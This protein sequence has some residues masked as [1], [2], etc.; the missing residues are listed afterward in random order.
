MESLSYLGIL[1]TGLLAGSFL[2]LVSDRL[3]KT[4]TFV[5]GR[6]K[7][8]FCKH[9]LNTLDLI[10]V[11]SF[12]LSLGKCRYCH[13]KISILHP[14]SELVTGIFFVIIFYYLKLNNLTWEFYIYYFFNFSLLLIIFWY[15]YKYYEI[16]FKIV[17]LGSIFS[18]IF[19]IIYLKNLTYENYLIELASWL[20]IF[21]F[22]FLVIWISKGGMGGGDLKLSIYLGI[23]L[24][25]PSSIYG[26]YYG[27][28]LGGMFGLLLLALGKK[29]LKSQIP[30]GPFLIIGSLL[31]LLI[32]NR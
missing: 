16:P 3:K 1:G 15:D 26:I 11:I 31:T 24:G 17:I 28:F 32:S 9:E 4:E 27:F 23:F 2:N 20:G 29:G 8:D 6:S 13:K 25:F 10:P 22:Y 18:F 30:F 21:L 5:T 14:I 19:R 7:C 12:I